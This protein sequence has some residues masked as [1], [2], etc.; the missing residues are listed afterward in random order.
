[1]WT[2]DV[3]YY[4]F[5]L[6][7]LFGEEVMEFMDG[8]CIYCNLANSPSMAQSQSTTFMFVFMFD[9]VLTITTEWSGLLK[10]LYLTNVC[11]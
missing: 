11:N 10:T 8:V 9:H 1:M 7:T 3:K 5:M 2:K 4:E 6:P